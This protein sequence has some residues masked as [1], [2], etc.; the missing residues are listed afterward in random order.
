[1]KLRS[2][3]S[4]VSD[5]PITA[6]RMH[7]KTFRNRTRSVCESWLSQVKTSASV[8]ATSESLLLKMPFKNHFQ[9]KTLICVT[10]LSSLFQRTDD[11][12]IRPSLPSF[13]FTLT[14]SELIHFTDC[15]ICHSLCLPDLQL[16]SFTN[17]FLHSYS[18]S[19]L[20]SS[21]YIFSGYVC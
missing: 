8:Y 18:D 12:S 16:I 20:V 11:N 19:V 3:T 6:H 21:F 5:W 14:M 1:M 13:L 10:G 9:N 17:P 15:T 4:R 7:K 2:V